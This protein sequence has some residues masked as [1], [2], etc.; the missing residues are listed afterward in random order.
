VSPREVLTHDP[1]GWQEAVIDLSDLSLGSHQVHFVYENTETAP[2]PGETAWIDDL[3]IGKTVIKADEDFEGSTYMLT[4]DAWMTGSFNMEMTIIRLDHKMGS[5]FTRVAGCGAS[6][7]IIV[8]R[9]PVFP[10]WIRSPG[11]TLTGSVPI[12]S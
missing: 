7:S 3:S 8:N 10:K 9:K 1:V 4:G 5:Y 2:E 11:C 6:L 12:W